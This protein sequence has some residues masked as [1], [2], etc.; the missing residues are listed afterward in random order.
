[1]VELVIGDGAR[2]EYVTTQ[3]IIPRRI[4]FARAASGGRRGDWVV[5]G[6]GGTRAKSRMDY[7]AEARVRTRG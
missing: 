4:G 1:M 5:L 6:L 7:L 2:L 3:S